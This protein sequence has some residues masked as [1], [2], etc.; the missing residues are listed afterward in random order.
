MIE[1]LLSDK[2]IDSLLQIEAKTILRAILFL[3]I[4]RHHRHIVRIVAV[5][6]KF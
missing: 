1:M 3:T 4:N 2:N 5:V 6:C